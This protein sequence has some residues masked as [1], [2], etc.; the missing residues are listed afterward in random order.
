M[1]NWLAEAGCLLLHGYTG[2]GWWTTQEHR[3]FLN[4]FNEGKGPG[5][6][7]IRVWKNGQILWRGQYTSGAHPYTWYIEEFSKYIN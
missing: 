3:L 1:K 6:P 5:L 7:M 2:S 4:T